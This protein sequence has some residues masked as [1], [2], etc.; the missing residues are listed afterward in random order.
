MNVQQKKELGNLSLQSSPIKQVAFSL[1]LKFDRIAKPKI[2]NQV[3]NWFWN[4]F[5]LGHAQKAINETPD[6]ELKVYLKEGFDELAPIF[7][8]MDLA[9]DIKESGKLN[10]GKMHEFVK[11]I[12]KEVLDLIP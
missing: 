2:Q 10:D 6:E 4:K 9:I 11:S 7:T 1:I 12:N 3:I 8:K 5:F